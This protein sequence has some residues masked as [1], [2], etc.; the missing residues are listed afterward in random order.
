[1]SDPDFSKASKEKLEHLIHTTQAGSPLFNSASY[2]LQ[3]RQAERLS[4]DM[5]RAECANDPTSKTWYENP[6]VKIVLGI[7][8]TIVGGVVVYVLCEYLA[9]SFPNFF[10]IQKQ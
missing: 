5:K 10:H 8:T 1:M 6:V 4:Q 9:H 3:K 7:L 2:E